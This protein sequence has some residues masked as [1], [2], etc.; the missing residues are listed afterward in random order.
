[1]GAAIISTDQTGQYAIGPTV[2]AVLMPDVSLTV[3]ATTDPGFLAEHDSA[4]TLTVLG[5]AVT[6]GSVALLGQSSSG[7][8][9]ATVTV[10]EGGLLQSLTSYGIDMRRS[11]SRIDNDGVIAGGNEGVIYAAGVDG[12]ELSNSGTISSVL[13]AAIMMTGATGGG[14]PSLF[15]IVNT[16]T[17]EAATDGVS[18]AHESLALTNHGAIIAF[19]R[20]IALSDDAT[21]DNTLTL[22]NTGLIQG[23]TTALS[24]TGHAD[25]VTNSGTLLGAVLLGAGDNRFDNSGTTT[26]AVSAEAGADTFSNSG[27]VTGVVDLGGGANTV[28]N[29]GRLEADLTLAEGDDTLLSEGTLLGGIALGDGSNTAI[30]AGTVHGSLTGGANADSIKLLGLLAGDI[31]LGDGADSLLA[32][33]DIDGN[34][35]MGS[36][37]DDVW[38]GKDAQFITGT[39]DGGS[40]DDTLIAKIDVEDAF[41][42]EFINLKGSANLDVVADG[43][44]STIYGNRGNNEIDGGD[45]DDLIY[46]RSGSDILLGGLGADHIGAGSGADELIGGAGGDTLKGGSGKDTFV[47]EATTDSLKADADEILDFDRGRD[48]LDLSALAEDQINWVGDGILY[49][50]GVA[51]ARYKTRDDHVEMRVDIDGNGTIDM[52][53]ILDGLTKLSASDFLL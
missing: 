49:K 11:G 29:F 18:V 41:D 52:M 44:G 13:G 10:G 46:G 16:G 39:L 38:L 9:L 21:L 40:G 6:F 26:G 47:Y 8:M 53:V 12:G 1:M 34:I 32:R 15:E 17:L 45:G 25:D 48:T 33:G 50:T 31:T 19:G 7:T 4:F 22:V 30:L 37:T 43:I 36:G 35:D 28:T 27:V 3:E 51:Q 2:F 20:G 42:F 5:Q 14:A 24:A 23:D